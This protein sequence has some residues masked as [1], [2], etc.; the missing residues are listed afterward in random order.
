MP[1]TLEELE[2]AHIRKVL[3]E[4]NWNQTHAA[5]VLGIDRVTLY[6]KLK[7]YGWKKPEEP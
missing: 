4:F 7:K 6:N 2:Q 3:E 5:R 1:R